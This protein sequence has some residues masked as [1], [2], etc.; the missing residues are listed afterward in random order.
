VLVIDARG[1]TGGSFPGAIQV[2]QRFLPGGIVVMT[3][4]QAPEFNN[5]VFSSDSGMTAFDLPVVLLIDTKTMS[6]AEAVA[7]AWKE[8]NRATLV[9]LPTF[10][11]GAIQ[12]PVRL[13]AV[14]RPDGPR[15]GVL[16]LT[17]ATMSG[18]RG[19]P[20]NGAGVVPHFLEADTARQLDVAIAKA[21][22]LSGGMR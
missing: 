3:Q 9:G 12:S 18:P 7:A 10:G 1:N 6:S 13:T 14:D 16:V 17:V 8:H 20:I 11:K 21:I 2:A 15:S 5:R 22:E 19:G 4:G